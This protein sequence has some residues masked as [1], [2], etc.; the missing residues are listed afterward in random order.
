MS[1]LRLD[2][3]LEHNSPDLGFLRKSNK[4]HLKNKLEAIFQKYSH[5][6]SHDSDVIDLREGTIIVDNGHL[7][8]MQ[9]E[10]DLR[11]RRRRKLARQDGNARA[12]SENFDNPENFDVRSPSGVCRRLT[13]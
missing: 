5:D 6:F 4:L 9:N 3:D 12:L 7:T 10:L 8:T 11:N 2:A 1:S 13:N